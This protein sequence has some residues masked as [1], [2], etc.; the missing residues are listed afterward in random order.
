MEE[1]SKGYSKHYS[2]KK[3][4]DKVVK[5]GKTA[6]VKVTYTAMILYYTI[7]KPSVPKKA[8]GIVY[9]ALGYFI[10]PLDMIPDVIPVVGYADDIG[11]LLGAIGMVW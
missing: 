5:F 3:F 10:L 2:D 4:W 7:Q 1:V 6:G 11:M 9:G 8:K